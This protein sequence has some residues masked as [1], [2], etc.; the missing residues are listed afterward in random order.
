MQTR[1]P[2]SNLVVAIMVKTYLRDGV[3]Q[4][5][6]ESIRRFSDVRYRLYVAD[7]EPVP[8]GKR[9]L[10]QRLIEEG[11]RVVVLNAE[12]PI[13]VCYARNRLLELLEDEPYVLRLDDDFHFCERTS[14]SKM[15]S[16]LAAR[17]EIGA[18]ADIEIQGVDGK[19]VKQGQ[20]SPKQGYFFLA[21]D[22]RVLYKQPVPVECWSWR[23]VDGVR[24]AYADFTRNFLLV[25]REVFSG[26]LWNES[27]HINGEHTDFML[28]LR[29][30]GWL[31]AFTPDSAHLHNEPSRSR[32]ASGYKMAR[33]TSLGRKKMRQVF[34]TEW[35]IE[36]VISLTPWNTPGCEGVLRRAKKI[37]RWSGIRN[38]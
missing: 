34:S 6:I 2:G 5:L 30:N 4:G 11:H 12:R 31:L 7:E 20:V 38:R 3:I 18:I 21:K 33:D 17:P 15:I 22:R 8:D 35:G 9:R 28:R 1:I 14:L 29:K 26:V 19:G 23:S 24:Y 16:L 27:L 37:L 36:D 32:V 13:S 10:Y 25:R